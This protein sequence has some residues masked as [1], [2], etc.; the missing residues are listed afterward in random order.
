VTWR[1]REKVLGY[2]PEELIG[3]SGYD[4]VHPDHLQGSISRFT[5]ST[6]Q[7]GA[8]VTGERLLLHKDGSSRWI[9][10]VIVNLLSEPSVQAIVMHLRDISERKRAEEAL[11]ASEERFRALIQFSFDVYWE[12]DAQHRFVRQEFSEGLSDA[13]TP[14]SEIGKTRWELPYLEPDEE[15]WRKHRE[16]LDAHLPFRDFELARPTPDGGKRYVSVS[17]LPAFDEAGH[18]IGYRGVGRHI[19]ERKRIEEALRQREKELREIVETIPAMT[20]TIAPD[21]RDAFIGKRFFEYSGLSE[22]KARGSGWKVTVHPDDLGLYLRKWRPSL[23]SGDPVEFETRV[24]RAD[25]EYRWFLARAVAQRDE[26]GNIVK[27]YEVLT[28]IEDRK[29]AEQALRRSEAYLAEAQ[30]LSHTGSFAYKPSSRKTLFWSEELFRIFKLDPRRGIPDYD[31]TRRLVHPDDLE[32]V[33]ATCL[34]GFREKA[35]FSQTYR[36]LLRDGTVKHLQAVWH[37]IVD[38]TGE[39]AEYVGTAADVTE[40]EQAE[41]N[42]KRAEAALRASEEQWKAVFENNPVMYFMV[43]E[44]GTIIS[45]NPFGAEQ[46]GYRVDELIGHPVT[47]VFYEP[48][49]AVVQKNAAACFERPGQAMSWDLRKVRKNGEVIWVRETARATVINNCPVLLIVCE[50]ISEGKHAAE[51]LREAQMELAHANRIATMGHL[52]AS[53]AHEVSQPVATARNNASAALNFLDRSPPDLEEVKEALTCVLSDTD[54]A[55]DIIGR[56]RDHI[57]KAPP[58]RDNFDLNEAI[59]EVIALARSEVAKNGVSVHS[60]LAEGWCVVHADHVQVQQVVLNLIL[61]AIE[62]MSS[63]DEGPRELLIST[64]HSQTDGI[65]VA[66]RDSGPGIDP[67][68]LDRVF[69]AFYTTKSSGVGMGLS[70]CRSIIAAHGGRLWAEANKPKGAVF[71]FTLPTDNSNL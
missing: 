69:D 9:E 54:R 56:I 2:A 38:E 71:R 57:K 20:V 42:R 61:N 37:P 22:E 17:G 34:Q 51:A 60:R 64:E 36:L 33:S 66:V 59:H 6:Q 12:T 3:R 40:R 67:E 14:G 53:I 18:F 65:I 16:T 58:R 4:L 10:N 46:L 30:R 32:T 48:D 29:R 70:I 1:L 13:P 39:V 47:I 50:D 21:G 5:R 44:T 41:Q 63:G 27:W 11:R 55:R 23:M 15:A 45:V 7:P 35:E 62:A 43:G 28:D 25:G 19:T 31:E 26:R 49:R 8:V 52:T 24:R 68:Q